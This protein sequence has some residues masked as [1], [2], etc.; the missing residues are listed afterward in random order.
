VKDVAKIS[1]VTDLPPNPIKSPSAH[2]STSV[3]P[4]M[5]QYLEI[6]DSNPDALLFFRMGDFYEMFFNDAEQAAKALDITLTKRGKHNGD[7]V[8]MCGVPVHAAESYLARLIQKGF[9]VAVCE[10]T[11]DP[12]EAK[13]RGPKSIV[14]RDVVRLVTPGTITEDNLLD[15]RVNNFLAAVAEVRGDWGLAWV[16]M[17]TGSFSAQPL[18]EE[19]LAAALARISPEELLVPEGLASRPEYSRVF[20]EICDGL[21]IRANNHFDSSSARREL[22]L[23]YAVKTIEVF[24]DFGL[25]EIS[26]CGAIVSYIKLTQK[27]RM[28]PLQRPHR[29]SREDT[30]EIDA[31]TRINL[32]L[33][34]TTSGAYE[35]SLISVIDRTVSA[36]GGRLL[37]ARLSAPLTDV[38]TIRARYDAV[39]WF[40]D[41]TSCRQNV[42]SFL[43][44]ASDIERAETRL[45]MG[46]GGPRDIAAIRSGLEVGRKI[47]SIL[48]EAG[49]TPTEITD[50]RRHLILKTDLIGELTHALETELPLLARDGGFIQ[51]GYNAELDQLRGLRDESRK[52][53]TRLQVQYANETEISSLKIRHNN[54]L[55]YYVEVTAA[56]SAN[57]PAAT[58]SKF[59][60]RQTLTNS[61]RYTTVELGELQGRLAQA[62]ERALALENELFDKLVA[63]ILEQAQEI[64]MVA[65]S[66]AVLDVSAALASLSI[67]NS[68]VRPTVD[69]SHIFS[70]T[71]G[72][73]PVVETTAS[74]NLVGEFVSN[75]LFF[76]D[77]QKLWLLTGPNM[78][79][80]ST[81]LRQN[82]LIAILAQI[83]SFVPAENAHIGVVDRLFSRV[84][85]S[86]DLAR[87]HST[88]MVEMIETATILNQATNRSLVILDEIGRGTATFDGLSIAWATLEHL[89]EVNGCRTLFATHFQ[90]LTSLTSR[91]EAM[92][93]YTMRIK[94]WDG[95]VIFLHEVTAGAA[96]RSYGIHVAK[97]A[98]LPSS[99]IARSREVLKILEEEDQCGELGKLSDNLPLFS[100]NSSSPSS[101]RQSAVERALCDINPDALSPREALDLLYQLKELS[102]D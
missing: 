94:E 77:T 58:D 5:A 74:G 96:D 14:R 2:L 8:P 19:G 9:R 69:D 60:H 93:C 41:Q 63:K 42:R 70:I 39:S 3:T 29:F 7:D 47:F 38:A 62:G 102:A 64:V 97:L 50:T 12:S 17:S 61:Q 101:S 22:E 52:H 1:S 80:K 45:I 25:A 35:G 66:L 21:T 75:D 43:R 100:V 28:P 83:G 76:T 51:A 88:F 23:L 18:K 68:Y 78:A 31:A 82:A 65:R 6:K 34:K 59:I 90:E 85:A 86:D 84:G 95:E 11:E 79:G 55:G 98:G 56:Q 24:G 13:K 72:R 44:E 53:I 81:F 57:M 32:E 20:D 87:G 99:V 33:T 36:V 15:A 54:V 40:I 46:R 30:L 48:T 92:A 4:M 49:E 26:A 10:Q 37:A 73:H 67:E 91:L 27:G 89:H 71:A 16:D